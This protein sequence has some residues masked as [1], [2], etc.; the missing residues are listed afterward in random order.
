[1]HDATGQRALVIDNYDS[2]TFN[3]AQQIAVLT[4]Q[5]P[6]VV[7]NDELAW[8]E[9]G[10][11]DFD[12]VVVSPGPGTPL[13]ESDLGITRDAVLQS[14]LPLLG[15]CLGLQALAYLHDGT[16]ATAPVIVHGRHSRIVH[17]GDELFD[18]IPSG[19]EA[20]RY[21]SLVVET[22]PPVL[23]AIAW[24]EDGTVMGVRHRHALQWGVQFHPESIGTPCGSRLIANFLRLVPGRSAGSNPGAGGGGR[25]RRS[26]PKSAGRALAITS[27]A[28]EVSPEA[29][30]DGLF[31][32]ARS[33]FWLDSSGPRSERPF[34]YM[35]CSERAREVLIT[36]DAAAMTV[37][38]HRAGTVTEHER[39][40]L[41]HLDEVLARVTTAAPELPFPFHGGLVGYLGYEA[42]VD[43][44][45]GQAH[46]S[47]YPDA[48]FLL[49]D[50]FVAI[51]HEQRRVC[52]V[53]LGNEDER[54]HA[55]RWV[56]DTARKI[57]SLQEVPR[58]VAGASVSDFAADLDRA[59]YR[60]AILACQEKLRAGESYEICLTTQFRARANIDPFE[61]YCDLRRINPA[62]YAAYL[63]LSGLAVLCSSPERFLTLGHDGTVE[64]KPI[65]GTAPRMPDPAADAA[66]AAALRSSQKTISE[67]LMIT[68]VLRNDLGRIATPGSVEVPVFL[69]VES[70]AS[71]HQLVSTIRARLPPGATA[72]DCLRAMFP[73]G[74]M[75][76]APRL[77]TMAIIDELERSARGVYSGTL[78]YL[79]FSGSADLNIVIR[80]MVLQ[81]GELAIGAGGAITIDSSPEEELAEVALKAEA[82]LRAV[83]A[84]T[85][86]RP[87]IGGG[88]DRAGEP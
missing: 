20:V 58:E 63:Q 85:G 4:G 64:T 59:S 6:T 71:V 70:Y 9:I 22:V 38:E 88:W 13:R 37:R 84:A 75:T 34:S 60:A 44:G 3:L 77:R 11:A 61:L 82:L 86:R 19:F 15:I 25:A 65:K 26:G 18:G 54:A 48:A 53:A 74:S 55:E 83:A 16:I 78:G 62:P 67:N 8:S 50:R 23:T 14:Q 69:G 31:R 49:V 52:V 42:K 47:S 57:A 1:M 68:D 30:F 33:S 21:H 36:Y 87:I 66:A 27:L 7:K 32:H 43:V 46:S 24:T 12:C 39:S 5:W 80:T 81:H 17:S 40:I 73:G 72:V 29:L 28:L 56:A 35:G 45:A 10:V 41:D 51:D 76:G 79:S 2:Y